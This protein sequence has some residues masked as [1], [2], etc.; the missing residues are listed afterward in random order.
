MGLSMPS[1]VKKVNELLKGF[2]KYQITKVL[3]LERFNINSLAKLVLET[4]TEV[5]LTTSRKH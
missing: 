1:Y 2:E 4:A 5:V 3:K